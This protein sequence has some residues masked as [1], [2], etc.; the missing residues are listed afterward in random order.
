MAKTNI[1]LFEIPQLADSNMSSLS[2]SIS[3][4]D[5]GSI[6]AHGEVFSDPEVETKDYTAPPPYV[7]ETWQTEILNH[8]L[9]S[10]KTNKSIGTR[11][12]ILDKVFRKMKAKKDIPDSDISEHRKVGTLEQESI[13]GLILILG[14]KTMVRFESE[15][16]AAKGVQNSSR[17]LEL[18]NSR[19]SFEETG[20]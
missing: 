17:Q 18:P 13:H 7:W 10:Y 14:N 12:A 1:S 2:R 9:P 4:D 8:Y 3:P 15:D 20:D 16:S 6:H 19:R 11:T 5:A